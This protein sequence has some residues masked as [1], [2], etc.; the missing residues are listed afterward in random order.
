MGGVRTRK[1]GL[2]GKAGYAIA[3]VLIVAIAGGCFQNDLLEAAKSLSDN[4]L[5]LTIIS[6]EGGSTV[7]AGA[8][9]VAP[10]VATDISAAPTSGYQ[11]INW[12]VTS[13]A[14]A[15]FG[16]AT[17]AA[18]NVTLTSGDVTVRGNFSINQVA[19]PQ[20][21]VPAGTYTSAQS[22]SI[23]CATGGS[24]IYYT[25]N[26]DD[27]TNVVSG[28]NFLFSGA[29]SLN[30]PDVTTT[31]RARAYATDM[32]PSLISEATYLIT[33]TVANPV[34]TPTPSAA[35]PADS[36]SVAIACATSGSAIRYTTDGTTP[37][38]TVGTVYSSAITV[39]GSCTIRAIAY[40]TNWANSSVASQAI[41]CA[42]AKNYGTTPTEA[43]YGI[44][45]AADGGYYV[46]GSTTGTGTTR[47]LMKLTASGTFSWA[48]SYAERGFAIGPSIAVSATDGSINT[49]GYEP[50]NAR[51]TVTTKMD[52]SA[53]TI[54]VMKT[55]HP[56]A[57]EGGGYTIMR[58]IVALPDG[59]FITAGETNDDMQPF[60]SAMI[61]KLYSNL[62]DEWAVR[63]SHSSTGDT[64]SRA[65]AVDAF[66]SGT[67]VNGFVMVGGIGQAS[68]QSLN[69]VWIVRTNALG[70]VQSRLVYGSS[71]T[72]VDD[73]AYGVKCTTD[74][75]FIVVGKSKSVSLAQASYDAFV[76]K[77]N[78]SFSLQWSRFFGAQATDDVI[79]AVEEGESGSFVLAGETSSF[80]VTGTDAWIVK[81]D[82][83]GNY[84][85]QKT[86]GAA[87]DEK[88]YDLCVANDGGYVVVGSTTSYG[89]A[90]DMWVLKLA[91]DG[92]PVYSN[93]NLK[94]GV[95]TTAQNSQYTLTSL[96]VSTSSVNATIPA[97]EPITGET[98]SAVA[99]WTSSRQYQP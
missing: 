3:A 22:I 79:Y 90:G 72:N 67:T 8:V 15:S 54:S 16:S 81:L 70:V 94:L 46:I 47:R 38:P 66:I 51:K 36:F 83:S 32:T 64:V 12:E 80:G 35:S 71:G 37:S 97:D 9:R 74:G 95:D 82:S 89:T 58:S 50:V 75:G 77:F 28:T 7:P 14:G 63:A 48:K 52:A 60:T 31:I 24:Q 10:S 84:L 99:G 18:T 29:I 44:A 91:A 5:T 88:G 17:A 21:N 96:T 27:P 39:T 87:G 65:Y 11:F 68:N 13:G 57:S 61:V 85:W 49:M 92:K 59:S 25:T 40:K 98:T 33:G 2:A 56:F 76:L 19:S 73:V 23:T 4:S 62:S 30:T 78:S 6:S 26:G 34:I 20:F 43:A 55:H 53:T 45:K 41:V 1:A 93:G 69:D 86:Y 42:W